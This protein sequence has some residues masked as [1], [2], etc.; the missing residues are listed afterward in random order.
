MMRQM[1]ANYCTL[2]NSIRRFSTYENYS[3]TSLNYDSSRRP[4]G[5]KIIDSHLSLNESDY[6]QLKILDA[7]CGTGNYIEALY[8]MGI[9]N[10]YAIELNDG[11]YNNCLVKHK[12]KIKEGRVH[13]SQCSMS[14]VIN[15]ENNM[16]N[17][18]CINQVLHHLDDDKS[19]KDN[20]KNIRLALR[21]SYRCL[22]DNGILFVNACTPIQCL[23][24]IWY[25]QFIPT[26][27]E[28]SSTKTPISEWF[29]NEFKN[30]GFQTVNRYII[31]DESLWDMDTYYNL[32]CI[33]NKEWRD[34]DSTF[35]LVS[36]HE[37]TH[38]QYAVENIIETKDKKDRFIQE[39]EERKQ[40]VGQSTTFVA[41]KYST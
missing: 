35:A 27:G 17:A 8:T 37:L 31:T 5:L 6:S 19:R 16:F 26:T 11:M 9:G 38:I 20:F 29:M 40:R 12:N 25:Y 2:K 15:F 28:I 33:F 34:R 4:V 41:C 13:L 39:S 10:I 22:D 14:P 36:E 23:V 7:G 21:E 1:R 24:G 18:I 30:V 32:E 3:K